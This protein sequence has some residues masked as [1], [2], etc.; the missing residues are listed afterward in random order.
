M[1][2]KLLEDGNSL[3]RKDKLSEAVFRYEYA[4]KKLPQ[5]DKESSNQDDADGP[6]SKRLDE[7]FVKLRSHLLL[8]LSRAQRRLGNYPA[9]S[10]RA[11]QALELTQ[12]RRGGGGKRRGAESDATTSEALWTRAKADFE[13]GSADSVARALSDL[14][15]AVRLAPQNLELHRFTSKVKSFASQMS[16]VKRKA[17]REDSGCDQGEERTTVAEI[18]PEEKEDGEE[19]CEEA[20]SDKRLEGDGCAIAKVEESTGATAAAAG[21]QECC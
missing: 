18:H 7:I 4:L 11:T 20:E 6:D 5:M 17:E 8:N 10:A 14:R 1:L 2:N 9:A 21:H 12:T 16:P 13:A 3:F 19:R 15:E